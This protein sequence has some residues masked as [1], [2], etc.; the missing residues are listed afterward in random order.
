MAKPQAIFGSM[1]RMLAAK[2]LEHEAD[3]LAGYR[4]RGL[5]VFEVPKHDRD[6]GESFA[7]WV[8]RVGNPMTD[9][10]DV[11]YQMPFA[12]D[13]VRGIADFLIRVDDLP[14]APGGTNRSTPSWPARRPSPDTY[15]SCASTPMP[16]RR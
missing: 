13:G 15:C 1:A 10:H 11:I 2:G 9:G 4:S 12:H 3:C 6:N 7:H 14:P 8:E 5:S 16:S